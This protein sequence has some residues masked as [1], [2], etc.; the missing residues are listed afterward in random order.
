MSLQSPPAGISTPSISPKRSF[1]SVDSGPVEGPAAKRSRSETFNGPAGLK[2]RGGESGPVGMAPRKALPAPAARH[3]GLS[4]K[5]AGLPHPSGL[6]SHRGGPAPLSSGALPG[7]TGGLH[8]TPQASAHS[9]SAEPLALM[10]VPDRA[11]RDELPSA[12]DAPSGLPDG[13]PLALTNF[14]HWESPAEPPA[15]QADAPQPNPPSGEPLALADV[16]HQEESAQAP[17]TSGDASEAAP[18]DTPAQGQELALTQAPHEES[19]AEP[20]HAETDVPE[21]KASSSETPPQPHVSHHQRPAVPSEAKAEVPAQN[22]TFDAPL[23]LTSGPDQAPLADQE[24]PAAQDDAPPQGKADTHQP[25]VPNPPHTS[26]DATSSETPSAPYTPTP[27]KTAGSQPEAVPGDPAPPEDP[28][29]KTSA[30]TGAPLAHQIAVPAAHAQA[31]SALQGAAEPAQSVAPQEIDISETIDVDVD[32]EVQTPEPISGP[33]AAT[34]AL[35][36]K[37]LQ[38]QANENA[39][40]E[41]REKLA[42]NRARNE[43]ANALAEARVEMWKK[44]AKAFKDGAG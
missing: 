30:D 16:P 11:D 20:S 26:A 40:T 17:A 19:P 29:V 43:V 35:I 38:Q 31:G 18:A 5:A 1:E 44:A 9:A 39:L 34:Q 28:P 33:D 23:T 27:P 15:A 2:A 25:A 8:E 36:D 14:S 4:G 10:D 13:A 7:P 42:E 22:A 6:F 12:A 32:V 21:K 41:L 37:Q 3:H 24:P